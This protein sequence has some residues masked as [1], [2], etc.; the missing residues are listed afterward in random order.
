ML[1]IA[2]VTDVYKG[3]GLG[4]YY[5]SR[6]LYF[7]FKKK[8]LKTDFFL[9]SKFLNNINFYQIII[10]DLPL[11]T[12]NLNFLS[13]YQKSLVFSLDHN[14]KYIVDA[15]ISIF[16]KSSYARINFI[17]LK[18]SII[19]KEF[20]IY[21]PNFDNNLLFICIGSSDLKEKRFFLKKKYSKYFRNVFLSKIISKKSSQNY[22]IQQQFIFNMKNCSLGIS[23][24]GTTL[25]ELIYYKKIIIVYPQNSA[26]KKFAFFLKRKGFKIFINPKKINYNFLKKILKAK[27]KSN[28]ID[29]KG[30][31]R[32]LY[33]ISNLYNKN[34]LS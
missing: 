23:N 8:K 29:N 9:Y 28:I 27:Q 15:N 33:T 3:S 25:L 30:M 17:N 11:K 2:I 10:I 26:E 21:K 1:K 5:R 22:K 14:Q 24:G 12:Y 7:F 32:I 20:Q 34:L 6:E 31:H 18:Y 4:N 16:K 13:N 19:R